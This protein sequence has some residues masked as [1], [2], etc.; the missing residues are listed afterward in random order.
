MAMRTIT[1]KLHKPGKRKREIIDEAIYNYSMAYQYL[2]D[3]AKEDI[4]K[5]QSQYRDGKGRYRSAQISK[6]I[7]KDMAK[8]LNKFGIE[9]FKDSLVID[10]GM[11]VAGYLALKEVRSKTGFPVAY[12]SPERWIR[13]YDEN[14]SELVDGA[15]SES[16]FERNI[17]KLAKKT[18]ALK[19]ILFC[20]YDTKRNYCLLYDEKKDRYY[21]K[22]Y[23]LNAKSEKRQVIECRKD[24]R[25]RYIH[26]DGGEL[27]ASG[28]RERFILVPLSFGKWQE[29]FLKKALEDP[30]IL[31]TARLAKRGDEYFLSLNINIEDKEPIKTENY[32]GI[33]R[34]IKNYLNITVVNREGVI[35]DKSSIGCTATDLKTQC[36]NDSKQVSTGIMSRNDLHKLANMV[37]Q[38]AV[39]SKAQV[40][41]ESFVDKGD[42]LQWKGE[43][44][45]VYF[46]ALSCYMYNSLVEILDYKL[47]GS[48]LP[49]PVKVSPVG[50]FYT[51]PSC[52]FHSKDNRFS[53]DMLIC[54]ACGTASYIEEAGSLNLSK[55][56]I[57]YK[58]DLL[59]IKV[60]RTSD[61]IE[62]INEDLGLKFI[63]SGEKDF[64]QEFRDE[65]NR[66]SESLKTG[67]TN[68]KDKSFKKRYSLIKK[69]EECENFSD[70]IELEM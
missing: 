31:K 66:I 53:H 10:F 11:T 5:I 7:D 52:N 26:K 41:V 1:L 19:P 2:L 54:I 22:L 38:K 45:Q 56:L 32:L 4:D 37:V 44:D 58:K 23:L 61:G 25:L 16:T 42:R 49:P 24:Y 63:P 35:L 39:D 33:S 46:P 27:E 62:F 13:D 18:S 57:Q 28:R 17:T 43:N 60:K 8:E 30:T 3:K 67:N 34:G 48:G 15:I 14:F 59:K 40:I 6:W 12:I 65:I 64:L 36:F 29:A 55:K 68:S 70:I 21:A 47:T 51:C 9:P 69:L 20:R 50:I